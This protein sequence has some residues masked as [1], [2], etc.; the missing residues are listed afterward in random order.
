MA[1]KSEKD[2]EA[3]IQLEN[4]KEEI[5]PGL[6]PG[7]ETRLKK[8][9]LN[10][11]FLFDILGDGRFREIA[12]VKME[13]NTDGTIRSIHYIDIALLDNIDK[14]R[15][16]RIITGVHSN[17]YELW[18]LLSQDTLDNG[19]NSLDYF[20]QMVKIERGIG[21]VNTSMGGG[22]LN[23]KAEKSKMIG[24]EFTDVKSGSLDTQSVK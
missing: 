21:A 7:L 22:L 23:I 15:L 4:K 6:E 17:K 1:R 19:K 5:K 3:T 9:T 8:T 2:Q 20:H 12:A 24:S 10:H 16:K 11:I 14:G 18:D 13:K